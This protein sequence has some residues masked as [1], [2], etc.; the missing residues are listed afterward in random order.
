MID[1]L[2]G[3]QPHTV[4]VKFVRHSPGRRRNSD[5]SMYDVATDSK[6]SA[7][8]VKSTFALFRRR[9]NP[10][11]RPPQLVDVNVFPLVRVFVYFPHAILQLVFFAISVL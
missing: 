5:T 2:F 9:E 4:V 7:E 11:S 3:S 1:V 8:L 6:A 10:V